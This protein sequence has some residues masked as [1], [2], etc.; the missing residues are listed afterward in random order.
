M[1]LFRPDMKR[2]TV[3]CLKMICVVIL[4]A[5]V[6]VPAVYNARDV[7]WALFQL[8]M[9]S[10]LIGFIVYLTRRWD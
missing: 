1:S 9:F 8:L 3:T 10:L 5:A 6:V 4:A 2:Y 7:R